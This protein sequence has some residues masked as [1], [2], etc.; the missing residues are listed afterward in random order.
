M[1]QR[2]LGAPVE[3]ITPEEARRILPGIEI[4]DLAG[5]TFCGEDGVATPAALV[6]GYATL[7]RRGGVELRR[8]AK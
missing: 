6:A 3:V 7:A 5:A 2:A 1:V 8:A 4:G